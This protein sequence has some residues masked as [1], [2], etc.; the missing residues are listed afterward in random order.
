[1][2]VVDYFLNSLVKYLQKKQKARKRKKKTKRRPAKTSRNKVKSKPVKK[3]LGTA[4]RKTAY[5]KGGAVKRPAKKASKKSSGIKKQKSSRA[6]AKNKKKSISGGKNHKVQIQK[7]SAGRKPSVSAKVK[8]GKIKKIKKVGSKNAGDKG[9]L[10]EV[11]IGEITHYF[12]RIQVVVLKMTRGK[13]TVGDQ[14]HIKGRGA[15]FIQK[16]QSLQIESVDV[17]VAQKGELVGLK[18]G[19]AVKPGNKV[20]IPA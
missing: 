10:K 5:Q 2:S 11:C 18:V 3:R 15:D 17:K 19:K 20:F 9:A 12:S 14:I 8:S 16:V 6:S 4:Q 1:M 7:K 13:L